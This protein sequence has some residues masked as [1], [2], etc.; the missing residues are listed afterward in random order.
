MKNLITIELCDE[1]R[2]RLDRLI[3]ALENAS[4]LPELSG[5]PFG[6]PANPA[7]EAPADPVPANP[8][9]EVSLPEFQKA[10]TIRCAE[11]AVM[12]D[13]VKALLNE[14]AEAASGVP[15]LKRAEVLSRLKEL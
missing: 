2:A 14:Y 5:T 7:P 9:P 6:I 1:D 15:P 10:L 8:D 13:K 12:R 4:S 3:A 11:S